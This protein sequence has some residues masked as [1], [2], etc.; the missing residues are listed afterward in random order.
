MKTGLTKLD[1]DTRKEKKNYRLR[2][3]V[4]IVP[5]THKKILTNRIQQ[6]VKKNTHSS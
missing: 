2:S 5:N 1:E 6:H 4:N 3:L